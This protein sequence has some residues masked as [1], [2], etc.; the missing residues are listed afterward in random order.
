MS[1]PL[2][3]FLRPW[4][5]SLTLTPTSSS[6]FLTLTMS[7][8]KAM[9]TVYVDTVVPSWTPHFHSGPSN[10]FTNCIIIFYFYLKSSFGLGIQTKSSKGTDKFRCYQSAHCPASFSP[11]SLV[12]VL[13]PFWPLFSPVTTGPLHI[14]FPLP[15][16]SSFPSCPG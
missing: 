2:V 11:Y 9:L 16:S 5:Y 6:P 13:Q 14:L 1:H 15:G 7:L 4:H 8:V 10:L 3:H 12:S